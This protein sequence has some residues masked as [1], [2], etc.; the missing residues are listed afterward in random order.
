M[1]KFRNRLKF[2]VSSTSVAA[3]VVS[4][5]TCFGAVFEVSKRQLCKHR[6]WVG[7]AP[8]QIHKFIRQA[9]VSLKF[10][11]SLIKFVYLCIVSKVCFCF[12][13]K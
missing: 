2:R 4:V 11:T 12:G 7:Y 3:I 9:A 8:L 1:G 6:G 5:K 10:K 13:L